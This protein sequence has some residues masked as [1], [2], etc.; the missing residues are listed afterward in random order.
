MKSILQLLL[1][2]A[3][4]LLQAEAHGQRT[5]LYHENFTGTL[6]NLTRNW[7]LADTPLNTPAYPK[8]SRGPHLHTDKKPGEYTLELGEFSTGGYED[9]IVSWG[10]KKTGDPSVKL[11]YSYNGG[12][13]VPVDNWFEVGTEWSVVNAEMGVSLPHC[14]NKAR[15]KLRWTYTVTNTGTSY[16]IDDITITGRPYGGPSIPS[17]TS[18]IVWK[19]ENAGEIPFTKARYVD[20]SPFTGSYY[21]PNTNNVKIQWSKE[22]RGATMYDQHV[23]PDFQNMYTVGIAQQ[24]SSSTASGYSRSSIHFD[25]FVKGINLTL[26]DIDE[27]KNE[28]I[29]VVRIIGYTREGNP[30]YP[31]KEHTMVTSINEFI[32]V[33]DNGF[34]IRSKSDQVPNKKKSIYDLYPDD[35][36]GNASVA[37]HEPVNRVDIIYSNGL[38]GQSEVLHSGKQKIAI[39]EV[40]WRDI[41]L[42]TPPVDDTT[43]SAIGTPTPGPNP[44]PVTL[45]A[46]DAKKVADGAQL[47]WI[48]ASEIDNERF[49]VE[50]SQD[51]KSFAPI[52]EVKGAGNS[53]TLLKYSFL[54]RAPRHGANYYRLTQYDYDGVSETSKVVYVNVRVVPSD[55]ASLKAYPNPTSEEL[56]I[57]TSATSATDQVVYIFNSVGSVVKSVVLPK[58]QASLNI[59]VRELPSGLYLVRSGQAVTRFYKQ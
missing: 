36:E 14:F 50:R 52:G 15:V 26:Y 35:P 45:T 11:E 25:S 20:A 7:K 4:L 51:G 49:V 34:A 6:T 2:C 13:W 18:H 37:F 31:K 16:A 5:T 27:T 23:T 47:N 12:V 19:Q 1:V 53:N 59:P 24:H 29:D 22:E 21:S 58:H 3:V 54:D 56:T 17:S 39:A 48:T 9:I 38:Y 28:C 10:G 30:I 8:A 33:G 55:K 40:T 42:P 41:A 32:S 57:Q 46:F 44:L 43:P